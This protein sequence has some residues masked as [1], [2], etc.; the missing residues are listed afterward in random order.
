[1]HPKI[2]AHPTPRQKTSLKPILTLVQTFSLISVEKLKK[3]GFR[4]IGGEF[5]RVE[6]LA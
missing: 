1:M 4:L 3:A 6:L 5:G 2:L